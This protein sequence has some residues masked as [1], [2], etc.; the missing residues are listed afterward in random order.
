MADRAGM[1]AF[2]LY[3]TMH[4]DYVQLLYIYKNG[5]YQCETYGDSVHIS[6]TVSTN[7]ADRNAQSCSAVMDLVPGDE[8]FV[9]SSEGYNVWNIGFSGVLIKPYV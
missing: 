2:E 3:W 6:N 8:V 9:M 5:D 4:Y 7:D 1:Y